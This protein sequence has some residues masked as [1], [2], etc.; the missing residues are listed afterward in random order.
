[1]REVSHDNTTN[2][3][4]IQQLSDTADNLLIIVKKQQNQIDKL[5]KQNGELT[6]ALSVNKPATIPR[7]R[8]RDCNDR[9]GNR[10][11]ADTPKDDRRGNRE[12]ADTPKDNG[13]CGVCGRQHETQKCWELNKNKGDCPSWRKSVFE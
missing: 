9:R 8:D 1:M 12:K 4:H 2:K 5:I 3:E 7:N 11:K 6:L 13:G 10:K